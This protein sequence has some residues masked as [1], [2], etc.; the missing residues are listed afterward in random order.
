MEEANPLA[1]VDLPDGPQQVHGGYVQTDH[2]DVQLPPQ[3]MVH[4]ISRH[5]GL[6]VIP[7]D[8][9]PGPRHT[10][11]GLAHDI[12]DMD[13]DL[14][15]D[16]NAEFSHILVWNDHAD[17]QGRLTS[18]LYVLFSKV[19]RFLSPRKYISPPGAFSLFPRRGDAVGTKLAK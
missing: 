14:L 9:L 7:G 16:P 11:G 12:A 2:R 4:R 3:K 18:R 19:T 1:G 15:T 10:V 13:A 17:I 8:Q 5:D 6:H